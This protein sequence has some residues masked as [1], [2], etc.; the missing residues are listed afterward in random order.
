MGDVVVSLDG[1]EQLI[2]GVALD[3]I[4]VEAELKS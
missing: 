1:G 2:F 4:Q 3:A